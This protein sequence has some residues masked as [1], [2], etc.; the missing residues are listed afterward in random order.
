[1]L[2][3]IKRTD[4]FRTNVGFI[5]FSSLP[6]SVRIELFGAD[7]AQLGADVVVDG[8]PA[9]GWKQRNRIFQAAGVDECPIGYA[10][11]TALTPGCEVWGY[12]SVVDNGS[13]D[14]TTVPLAAD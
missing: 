8:I 7:G 4:D 5:N 13:G 3:Q 2:S 14:P 11:V 9:G 10:V 1:M 6:C 12:A